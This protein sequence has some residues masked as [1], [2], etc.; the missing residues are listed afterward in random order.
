M[1]HQVLANDQ[2]SDAVG[3]IYDSA[4]DPHL[5]PDAIREVCRLTRFAAGGIEL[6]N[7]VTPSC[8]IRQQWNFAPGYLERAVA[9]YGS[10]IA[11]IWAALPDRMTRPLDEPM[12][13]SRLDPT[14]HHGPISILQGVGAATGL[15]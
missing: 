12:V 14:M 13:V 8:G 15:H 6:T 2:L 1:E 5:W 7:L 3:A 9:E 4:L 11:D 10:D